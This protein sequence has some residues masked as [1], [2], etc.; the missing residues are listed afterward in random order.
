M[1]KARRKLLAEAK[2]KIEEAQSMVRQAADEEQEYFGNMA[3]NLQGGEKGSKAEEVAS[4]LDEY[5]NSL[6]ELAANLEGIED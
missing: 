1:N 3:E 2:A 6:E 4:H 5:A